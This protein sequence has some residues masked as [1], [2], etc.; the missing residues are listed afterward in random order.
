MFGPGVADG[1]RM[2]EGV[3]SPPRAALTAPVQARLDPGAGLDVHLALA[4]GWNGM[5]RC[6]PGWLGIGLVFHVVFLAAALTGIGLLLLVPVLAWGGARALLEM[7]DGGG[8]LSDLF[9]GFT[10][11]GSVLV[12]S[13]AWYLCNLGLSLIGQTPQLVGDLAGIAWLSFAGALFSL[14]WSALVMLRLSFAFLYLVDRR[15]DAVAA[16]RA[17][18]ESTRGHGLKI[19]LLMIASMAVGLMG[20][21]TLLVGVIPASVVIALAWVSAYRQLSGSHQQSSAATA[22]V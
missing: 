5:L 16:F 1:P 3:Y 4:D 13:V 12:A 15:L 11:Y 8:R 22:P 9:A 20:M 2:V 6:F 19:L 7:H 18:W 14:L 17:S 21:L 10:D